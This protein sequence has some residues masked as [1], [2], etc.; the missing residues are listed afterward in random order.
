MRM[1]DK[2][3]DCCWNLPNNNNNNNKL[4]CSWLSLLMLTTAVLS[5]SSSLETIAL[6]SVITMEVLLIRFVKKMWLISDIEM[7]SIWV[8]SGTV[9][10]YFFWRFVSK[11][12]NFIH[13]D[14]KIWTECSCIMC[15]FQKI[16]VHCCCWCHCLLA[17]LLHLLAVTLNCPVV[18]WIGLVGWASYRFSLVQLHVVHYPL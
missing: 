14:V 9:Q 3:R 7:F 4:L 11:M 12:D 6:S 16:A 18:N 8:F 17:L 13:Y 15:C 1:L 2:F 5:N 10:S